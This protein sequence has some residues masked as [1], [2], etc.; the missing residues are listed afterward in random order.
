MSTFR[1]IFFSCVLS[2][3]TLFKD[4][5]VKAANNA[6]G[7]LKNG[8]VGDPD[9]RKVHL[10]HLAGRTKDGLDKVRSA[11]G[12]NRNEGY[13][14]RLLQLLGASTPLHS[15]RTTSCFYATIDGIIAW[16]ASSVFVGSTG[17]FKLGMQ[18]LQTGRGDPIRNRRTRHGEFRVARSTKLSKNFPVHLFFS[19]LVSQFVTEAWL[20][21]SKAS[22][23]TMWLRTFKP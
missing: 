5:L 23:T 4:A 17:I 10:F 8:C 15:W 11:R 7:H 9:P 22:I 18:C 20:P 6:L 13:H 2:G 19:P 21:N 16:Q 3:E 1:L 12:T 14:Q